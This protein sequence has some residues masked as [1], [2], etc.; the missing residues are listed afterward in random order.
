MKKVFNGGREGYK[1]LNGKG[2]GEYER[3]PVSKRRITLLLGV[4]RGWI[5]TQGW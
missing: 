1:G 4:R 2:G 5:I 3:S